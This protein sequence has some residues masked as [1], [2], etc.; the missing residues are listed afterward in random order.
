MTRL[1]LGRIGVGLN[2]TDTYLD[3]AA[4]LE[5]LGY[6]TIWLPGGQLRTLDPLGAVIGA[7]E[8]VTVASSIIPTGLY[9]AST[10][11]ETYS[12]VEKEHPGRF[13]VGLGGR[14]EPRQLAALE[15][16]LD[17]LD[18]VIPAERRMLAAMGPRKLAMARDRTAGSLPL[19]VT[20]E[21][22][23]RAREILGEDSTL[24]IN[25]FVVPSTDPAEARALIRT[26]LSFLSKIGGYVASFRSQGFTDEDISRLSD[27]L[28]DAVASWGTLER[29]SADVDA[30]FDAGADQVAINV[31]LPDPRQ[32]WRELANVLI[33]P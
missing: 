26:P 6:S 10:V 22:T 14:Q 20:P 23:A 15:A 29:I 7:T 27:R 17:E 5:R 8:R 32:G 2:V 12:A 31:L 19:L 4:E 3:D 13:L 16:Y 21:Y 18:P 25:Q 9:D 11:I 30:H 28:V 33:R 24:V 1:N